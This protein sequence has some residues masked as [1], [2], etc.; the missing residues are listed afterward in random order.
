MSKRASQF[1][2]GQGVYRSSYKNARRLAVTET[3][4]A[5]HS[6]DHERW[7]QL[8]FVVG[9][10]VRLSGNHTCLGRDGKR[11]EFRDIC[12]DLQ[13]RYPKDF[14][15]T[16]WHP[17]CRCQAI[18]ILK[19]EEELMEENRAIMRG[20]DPPKESVN[21]VKDVPEGFKQWIKD[22]RDRIER[23]EK[24]GTLPYFLRDNEA[25]WKEQQAPQY[26]GMEGTK[27]GRAAA[28][29][30]FMEYENGKPIIVPEDL[31]GNLMKAAEALGIDITP[32]TFLEANEGMANA[33]RGKNVLFSQN[34]Q[35]CVAI[36]EARL[37]GLDI[38]AVE[39]SYDRN[40]AQYI[41]GENFQKIWINPNTRTTPQLTVLKGESDRNIIE[42]LNKSTRAMGRYHVGLNYKNNTG[43]VVTAE[44]IFSGKIIYY[45]AQTGDFINI[46]DL[47]GLESVE[48]LK[49]DKMLFN[50]EMLKKISR[51]V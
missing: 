31:Q 30:A 34:C 6:A 10:E 33:D 8:D 32:M 24:K 27:L 49:V 14:K 22:N 50:V 18:S 40:S 28:K 48:L 19:T 35:C 23:A 47:A 11:H 13:G 2:P 51:P 46:N 17:Q 1:H 38:T 26:A 45:D 25:F 41:L 21:T 37:R 7:Q 4:M 44:R 39:Y 12:D 15:F 29:E 3:N 16:G 9:I 5:Y 20:E 36:H 42:K 43:H